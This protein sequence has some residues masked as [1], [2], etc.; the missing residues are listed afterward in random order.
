MFE[1][2]LQTVQESRGLGGYEWPD[3][4]LKEKPVILHGPA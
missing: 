4:A 2:A 3:D 1:N